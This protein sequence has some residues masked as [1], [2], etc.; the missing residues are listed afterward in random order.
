MIEERNS[1]PA[2]E[3]KIGKLLDALREERQVDPFRM[4]RNMTVELLE[5][6]NRKDVSLDQM[7]AATPD[8]TSLPKFSATRSNYACYRAVKDL[9]NMKYASPMLVNPNLPEKQEKR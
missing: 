5:H 6:Q 1:L 2:F 7:L 8:W 9:D 3:S 4:F